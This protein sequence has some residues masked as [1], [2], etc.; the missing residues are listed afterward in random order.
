MINQYKCESCEFTTQSE[1]EMYKHESKCKPGL[2]PKLVVQDFT[3][4]I[5]LCEEHIKY[6]S[7]SDYDE[8]NDSSHYIFEKAIESVYGPDIWEYI[9]TINP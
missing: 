1:A 7:S 3:G 2:P 9:N 4:L 6:I 5:S 8:D